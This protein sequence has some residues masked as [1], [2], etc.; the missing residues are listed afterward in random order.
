VPELPEVEAVRRTLDRAMRGMRIVRV[1][2]RRPDLRRPFPRGF[3]A[4]LT[5]RRITAVNRRGKYLLAPLDSGEALIVHLGMSGSFEITRRRGARSALPADRHDHVVFE[6]SSGAIVT[7]NDPRRFGLMD[8][9]RVDGVA[10]HQAFRSMGP[11]PLDDAFDAAALARVCAGKRAALKV[12][13]LD[14]RRVAGVGNIYASEA[15]HRAALSPRRRASTI[16]TPG[17]APRESAFRL[18]SAIKA[19]LQDAVTRQYQGGDSR[20]LVYERKGQPCPRRGCTGTIRQIT[21]AGRSTYYCP[22]CQ[23]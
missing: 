17:G 12:V 8:L 6:L 7:F 5:G 3:A 4:R 1:Q 13:L 10:A 21:Q 23:R 19:V 9:V 22:V 15:L 16:A 14:Q 11:E 20:F 18:V 2:L